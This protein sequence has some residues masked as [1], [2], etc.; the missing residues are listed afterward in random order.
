MKRN[1]RGDRLPTIC[2]AITANDLEL[3]ADMAAVAALSVRRLHPQA[4]II[5]VMDES[6]ARAIDGASHASANIA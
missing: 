6:T 3:F 2:F 1:S 5:L 4:Q